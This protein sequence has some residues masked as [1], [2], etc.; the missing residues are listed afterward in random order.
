MSMA[1]PLLKFDRMREYFS[2]FAEPMPARKPSDYVGAGAVK[3]IFPSADRPVQ[4]TPGMPPQVVRE[5]AAPG[6]VPA[7]QWMLVTEATLTMNELQNLND[8][9]GGLTKAAIGLN[10]RFHL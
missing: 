5:P 10:L 2:A 4:S 9:V 6:F 8:A 1:P 3:I 7:R